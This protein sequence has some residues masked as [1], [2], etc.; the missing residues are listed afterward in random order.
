MTIHH[1]DMQPV[2]LLADPID[3]VGQ[4]GEVG[5]KDRWADE[6]LSLSGHTT[7]VVGSSTREMVRRRQHDDATVLMC[8]DVY[9]WVNSALQ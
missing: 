2:G 4:P 3:V 7:N 6:D 8:R 9:G 1:V 5:R